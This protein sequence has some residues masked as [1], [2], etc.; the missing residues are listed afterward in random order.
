MEPEEEPEGVRLGSRGED[1]WAAINVARDKQS[2]LSKYL[3]SCPAL[4][5]CPVDSFLTPHTGSPPWLSHCHP[6]PLPLPHP[7]DSLVTAV[8]PVTGQ[9][10][11]ASP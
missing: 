6:S 8:T 3:P 10:S 2:K 7:S 1:S 9:L 11:R 4:P 5:S